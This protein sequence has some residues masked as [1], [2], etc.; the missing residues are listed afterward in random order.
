MA[1]LKEIEEAKLAAKALNE[2]LGFLEDAFVSIGQKIKNEVTDQL[3]NA[4]SQTQELGNKFS[5]NLNNAI[6]QNANSLKE[7]T[8]LQDQ[9]GKG[10]NVEAKIAKELEKIATRKKTIVRQQNI[11]TANGIKINE[12]LSK[13]LNAQFGIQEDT[14]G[15]LKL[16]NTE[17]QKQ[18]SLF[19]LLGEGGANLLDKL[20]KSGTA[21]KL[22]QLNLKDT[23][24]PTRLMEL[25]I[26]FIVEAFIS[27]DQTTE[28]VAKNLGISFH[29][30]SAMN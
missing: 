16:E 30:A 25:A 29:E 7:I 14:L 4:D 15:T 6:K 18:K 8:K 1:S 21:S 11:L 17:R 19:T 20:D 24:T 3:A 2:E 26:G 22:M 9:I 27:L 5:T 28:K 23:V 12:D 13:Q 10:V